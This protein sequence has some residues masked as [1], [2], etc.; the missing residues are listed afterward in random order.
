MKH[1]GVALLLLVVV[2]VCRAGGGDSEAPR[3]TLDLADGSRLIGTS[4]VQVV[5]LRTLYARLDVPLSQVLRLSMSDDH[6]RGTLLLQAGDRVS[7]ALDLKPIPLMTAFG[8]I[9]VAIEHIRSLSVT[10]GTLPREGLVLHYSF[11]RRD[12]P[13]QDESGRRADGQ[14]EGATW[15]GEGRRGGGMRFDGRSARVTTP[16][17]DVTNDVT[18]SAWILPYSW[19]ELENSIVQV[20]GIR[21]RSWVWNSCNTA[22]YFG[23]WGHIPGS[24]L[25]LGFL[26]QEQADTGVGIAYSLP[27]P[28][29]LKEWHHVAGTIGAGG[30]MLYLDGERVASGDST[31]RFAAAAAMI[32]GANDNGPQRFFN[33]VIDEVMVFDRA[34]S[35]AEIRQLYNGMR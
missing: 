1:V 32:I 33:G 13:A 2:A 35:E 9:T 22:I 24:H 14:V 3:L 18:W 29:T 23:Y 30:R 31:A 34:L 19:P 5:P 7:G 4:I 17:L 28:P 11:D 25:S 10:S 27:A 20:M 12:R 8:P 26:V 15:T 21:S 6:E 16:I